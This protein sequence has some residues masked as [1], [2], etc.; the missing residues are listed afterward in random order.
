MLKACCQNAH[1]RSKRKKKNVEMY[2]KCCETM[3]HSPVS[4]EN[5]AA[6]SAIHVCNMDTEGES[7]RKARLKSCSRA[8]SSGRSR[9]EKDR[10]GRHHFIMLS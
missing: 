6:P 1:R 9:V 5:E 3:E 8:G 10:K 7:G 2:M 4:Q